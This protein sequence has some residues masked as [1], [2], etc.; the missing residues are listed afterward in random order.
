MLLV[1]FHLPLQLDDQVL[2]VEHL[3]KHLLDRDLQRLL[4]LAKKSTVSL[5]LPFEFFEERKK[6]L[7]VFCH[8]AFVIDAVRVRIEI[9][10]ARQLTSAC[11]IS[12]LFDTLLCPLV[13]DELFQQVAY[14]AIFI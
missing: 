7:K 11:A 9:G 5:R 12:C 10:I 2:V 1:L 14:H 8:A 4:H 3:L 6:R 13:L